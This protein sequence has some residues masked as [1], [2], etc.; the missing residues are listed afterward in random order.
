MKYVKG[1]ILVVDDDPAIRSLVQAVLEAEGYQVVTASDGIEGV[2]ILDAEPR[3]I[4][5]TTVVLDMMMPGM[6]GLD[7]LTRMKL[8]SH[9]S[10]LPVIML[11]AEKRPEDILSGYS[12]G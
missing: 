5:F 7:V 8:H 6:H 9:T 2:K 11:T 1:R 4:N 12:T 10:D 3:P